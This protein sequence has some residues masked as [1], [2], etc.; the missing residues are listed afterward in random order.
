MNKLTIVV[1]ALVFAVLGGC[2]STGDMIGTNAGSTN[3]AP[4]PF[5]SDYVAQHIDD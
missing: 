3:Y 4:S 2:A 5:P 1:F